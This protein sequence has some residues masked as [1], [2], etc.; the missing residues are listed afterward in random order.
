[1]KINEVEKIIG[2]T[3]KNIRFY[4]AQGLLSPNR[5]AENGYRDY[6]DD[7]I[8]KLEQIKLLR[9][10]G[11]PI[12]EIRSMQDGSSTVADSMKRHG[13]TLERQQQ[14]LSKC[15]ELCRLLT[16]EDVI[17]SDLDT[18]KF[19]EYMGE[20]EKSG[21]SFNNIIRKDIKPIRYIGAATASIIMTAFMTAL[22]L[23]MLWAFKTDPEEAPPLPFMII[24]LAVPVVIVLGIIFSLIQ[25][26]HEI[27]RGEIDD[28]KKF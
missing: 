28:A 3:K 2:I 4:E 11:L 10:L 6:S 20:M 26:I 9:K 18:C 19:L 25:R 24:F 5:N 27:K 23:F 1:M 21:A 17:L 14:N 12:E 7:D 13:I 22:F 8:K 15:Q 16:T